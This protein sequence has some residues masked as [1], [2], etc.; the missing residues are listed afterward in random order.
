MVNLL[1]EA[2]IAVAEAKIASTEASLE[3]SEKMF[4]VSGGWADLS[5]PNLDRHWRNARTHT[6]HDPVSYKYR[7]VGDCLLNGRPPP[8]G[9][10][11]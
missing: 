4:S 3:V 8:V 2:S 7:A 5:T 1:E 10:K 9:T 11:P 6:I